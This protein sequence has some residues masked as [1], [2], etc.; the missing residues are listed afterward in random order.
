MFNPKGNFS[1]VKDAYVRLVDFG[2]Q[3]EFCHYPVPP[4]SNTANVICKLFRFGFTRWR[5]KAI[6]EPSGGRV[7]K[8]MIQKVKPFLDPE[9]SKKKMRVTVHKGEFKIQYPEGQEPG[10]KSTLNTFCHIRG[11]TASEK[12]KIVKLPS[13]PKHNE[14]FVCEYGTSKTLSAQINSIEITVVQAKRM[15]KEV[16]LGRLIIPVPETGKMSV[17]EEVMKIEESDK[18]WARDL[19]SMTGTL[20]MSVEQL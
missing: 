10:R 1:S 15:G 8:H 3:H 9:P 14:T 12:T 7:Y 16:Y 20:T 13:A 6:G 5:L 11:D 2:S 4:S 18:E 17:S 19:L